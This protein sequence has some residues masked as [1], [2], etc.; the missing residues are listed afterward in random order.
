MIFRTLPFPPHF[1]PDRVGSVWRVP[2][3]KLADDAEK[4][5]K[6]YSIP[7]VSEDKYKIC[8]L[9][10][11][12]QNTFC[13]PDFEL[14]VAGRSG[15]GAVDDN[16]RLCEFIYQNLGIISETCATMDTHQ[17]AQIFHSLFFINN[18]QEHP[19]PFTVVTV[20]DIET[21]KWK[22]NHK[23]GPSIGI[24]AEYAQKFLKHYTEKLKESG[25]YDLTVWPYHA[26]LGGIGHALVS[27]VEEALFF[28][29]I[30]RCS[31]TDFQIKGNN[32]LTENYSVISPEIQQGPEGKKIGRKNV[33]LVQKLVD[34]DAV[35][36]A[37]QAKSHCVAWTLQDLIS[38]IRH[39][40]ETLAE[41][42]Y[43][44][45][46][47][48]SPVVISGV[49]DYTQ[50]ADDYFIQFAQAGVNIVQSTEPIKNWP[51]IFRLL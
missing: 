10:V 41:K 18:K 43:L 12:V 40:D 11:D 9:L 19:A 48:C 31:L 8:L 42:I 33:D 45:E 24:T 29:G 34:F 7:P 23:L 28:H 13:I 21:G 38:E 27:S 6:D 39:K 5:A 30:A 44:I 47:C 50:K 36:I 46:D 32:S 14:Y 17:A 20:K 22:F 4:W 51:G 3:Q 49:V 1:S 35:I 26:M 15:T 2:Y 25:K 37:G 16:R